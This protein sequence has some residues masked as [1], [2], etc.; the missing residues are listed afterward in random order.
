MYYV[1][2][3]ADSKAEVRWWQ[4][5][6]ERDTSSSMMCDLPWDNG[7]HT[8]RAYSDASEWGCGAYFDGS[9]ISEP[10]SDEVNELTGI[11]TNHRNMPL[12]EAIAVAVAVNTWRVRFAGKHVLFMTDCTAVVHGVNKGRSSCAAS[13]WLNA[14]YKLINCVCVDYN[15]MLRAQHIKG[16]DNTL[17]DDVSRNQV[18]KF[19]VAMASQQQSALAAH[20]LPITIHSSC[21]GPSLCFPKRS[22]RPQHNHINQHMTTTLHSADQSTKHQRTSPRQLSCSG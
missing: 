14:V 17:A 13:E 9:Y 20:V 4:A 5:A 2:L 1:N 21:R 8:L 19:L 22:S 11:N 16:T 6:I 7:I 10:W 15:I 3:H 18:D 12:C